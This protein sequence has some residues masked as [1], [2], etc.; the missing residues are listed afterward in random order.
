[1]SEETIITET[2]GKVGIITLNRP[3][4]LNALNG[5]L[6]TEMNAALDRF[7]GDPGIAVII[8]AGS[9]K[10]FAAGADIRE[11][12]DKTFADVTEEDFL[13][14]WDHITT[15]RKPII[16]AVAGY[17]LGG[18]FEFAL[19]CDTI[20]AAGNAKFALPEVTL[21]IIPGGGGTQ[22]LVQAVG[23]AKA[24]EMILTGRMMDVE[25]AERLG[26]VARV[27]PPEK[28][29]DEAMAVAEKIAALSQPVIASAKRAVNAAFNL[30]LGEGLAFERKSIHALFAL[31]DQKEGMAAFVEKR[32]PVFRDR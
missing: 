25:E 31:A 5:R 27:V 9:D 21:G 20:I 3:K 32:K 4:A 24:M 26:V 6:I 19:A 29:M 8:L 17:A 2:R 23:K 14:D 16:A 30:P 12:K 13:R 22:R 10:A 7:D 11:M 1:M 18:G 15:I 28:L